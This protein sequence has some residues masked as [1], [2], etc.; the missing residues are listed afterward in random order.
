MAEHKH[1]SMDI[2]GH[3]KTYNGFVRLVTWGTVA[4][5][6]ILCFLAVTNA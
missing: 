1:G 4:C 3:E 6:V 5:I 2:S